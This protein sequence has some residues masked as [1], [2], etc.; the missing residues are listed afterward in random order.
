VAEAVADRAPEG[1]LRRFLLEHQPVRGH[2]VRLGEA[3][4]ALQ[5]RQSYPP[6]V[7]GLLG[8]AGTAVVLLAATLKFE[9]TLT[10]QLTGSGRVRML[11]AQCTDDHQL[12]AIAHHDVANGEAPGFAELVGQGRL[13]VTIQSERT[14]ARYQGIV[15][16]EGESLQACLEHYFASSEQL[17]TRLLLAAD[18]QQAGGLL[19]QQL[20]GAQSGSEELA[21]QRL[22]AWEDVQAGL[23]AL[24]PEQLLRSPP[25]ESI[26]R[27]CGAHDCR[28]LPATPVRFACRC[29]SQR[30]ADML[31][32][33]GEAEAQATLAEQGRIEVSCEFCG[34][35]YRYDAVDVQRLF[36]AQVASPPGP[37]S[38]N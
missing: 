7:A 17:P 5:A 9:G 35:A 18:N 29:S 15:P 33:L 11:V 8:E 12:R 22:A 3:W 27:V 4:Q 16:L 23:A 34:A 28:L 31:R 25:E 32:S 36:A 30:V 21:A 10:L 6:P 14:G 38:L 19:V 24:S 13:M 26:T 2:W 1:Q 37:S 20:P